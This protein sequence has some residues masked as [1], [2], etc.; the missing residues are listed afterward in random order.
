MRSDFNDCTFVGNVGRDSEIHARMTSFSLAVWN[1][2]DKPTI[3]LT[4]KCF[5]HPVNVSKGEKVKVQGR[6]Y[7]ETYQAKDGTQKSVWGIVADTVEPV[8]REEKQQ[9]PAYLPPLD[10]DCPF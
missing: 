4:V 8:E 2:R 5:D 6:L 1:G 9:K 3:W 7:F 10:E